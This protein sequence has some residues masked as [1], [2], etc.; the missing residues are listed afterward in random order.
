MDKIT[1]EVR[2]RNW[3]QLI[4]ACNSSGLTRAEWCRQNGVSLKSF[5]YRQKQ[6]RQE[7]FL[8]QDP[9][10]AA[11]NAVSFVELPMQE[12]STEEPCGQVSSAVF[13]PAVVIRTGSVT[14]E[15]SGRVSGKVLAFLGEVLAHAT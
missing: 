7:A 13:P 4:E 15:I 11:V 8:L 5:Y 3:A 12:L 2:T 14:V 6:L 1:H 10:P 9:P